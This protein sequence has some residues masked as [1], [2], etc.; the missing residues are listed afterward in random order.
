MKTSNKILLGVLLAF[1][2]ILTGIH[3]ALYAKYKSG[4]FVSAKE[5]ADEMGRRPLPP[6]KHVSITGLT[7]CY[8]IAHGEQPLIEI[9][10]PYKSRIAYKVIGDTLIVTGDSTGTKESYDRGI[11]NNTLVNL[12][13]PAT[14][15]VQL[16]Y[17]TLRLSGGDDSAHAP[18]YSIEL[19]NAHVAIIE[20]YP[21]ET[22][23][24]FNRLDVVTNASSIDL[25]NY[26]AINEL[27]VRSRSSYLNSRQ[28]LIRQMTIDADSSSSVVLSGKNLKNLTTTA[29]P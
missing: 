27:H 22:N 10:E 24:F 21:P 26:A 3:L 16:A 25:D 18:S 13:L 9:N 17:G 15:S 12:I 20:R 8:L 5:M 14:A 2:L 7:N 29:K 4:D 6:I 11:R 19:A 23:V 1:M 28:A